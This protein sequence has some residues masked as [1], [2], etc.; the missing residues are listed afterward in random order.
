M[1]E[2]VI[3]DVA[4]AAGLGCALLRYFNVAGAD[5]A[6]RSGQRRPSATHLIH[7]ISEVVAGRRPALQ[8]YGT[9]YPTAD[10]TCVRD[11]IHVSDL[12]AAHVAALNAATP[13]D[14]PLVLNL[15]DGAGHSVHDVVA[16]TE[17]V[18]GKPLPVTAAPRRA[19]DPLALVADTRRACSRLNWKPQPN[20]LQIMIRSAIA[21]EL[22]AAR[23]EGG[24]AGRDG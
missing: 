6:G 13:Q 9:D 24:D 15:G 16:A 5:A 23:E 11:Y 22:S 19:G 3:G 7:V 8:I 1:A 17:A 20:A 4:A 2:Q 14:P 18:I 21:W 10:G 12:A